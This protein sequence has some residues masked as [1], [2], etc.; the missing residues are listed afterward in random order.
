MKGARGLGLA[1]S[2]MR[3]GQGGGGP[4]VKGGGGRELGSG[5]GG[6]DGRPRRPWGKS[7]DASLRCGGETCM[8]AA[9]PGV[10]KSR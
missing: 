7:L 4:A 5:E 8:V 9:A 6:R 1:L 3:N 10:D 2:G